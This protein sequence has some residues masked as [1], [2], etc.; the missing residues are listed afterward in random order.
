MVRKIQKVPVVQTKLDSLSPWFVVNLVFYLCI[1]HY[2]SLGNFPSTV[3]DRMS[4]F[5]AGSEI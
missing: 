1:T 3:F 2:V 4:I 5:M